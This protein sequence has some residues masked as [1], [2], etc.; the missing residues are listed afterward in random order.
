V[1]L[2]LTR[3]LG[4]VPRRPVWWN[5]AIEAMDAE[6]LPAPSWDTLDLP[7]I[8]ASAPTEKRGRTVTTKF[9]DDGVECDRNASRLDA[10][11]RRA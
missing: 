1:S 9:P 4:A 7:P 2:P 3:I 11:T 5:S 6:D 10:R 8:A